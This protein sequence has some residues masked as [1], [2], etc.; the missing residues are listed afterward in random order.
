MKNKNPYKKKLEK[1]AETVHSRD[2]LHEQ[3]K[4]KTR[5]ILLRFT[6]DLCASEDFKCENFSLACLREYI[7]VWVDL[8][9]KKQE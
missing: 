9:F 8:H 7:E 6:C 2:D 3:Y 5:E 1:L 4:K